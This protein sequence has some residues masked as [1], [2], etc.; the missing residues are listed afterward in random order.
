[1][2]L[3]GLVA[4]NAIVIPN[5]KIAA[6]LLKS[7]SID[8]ELE[9]LSGLDLVNYINQKQNLWTTKLSPKF[10][11]FTDSVKSRLM[12]VKMIEVPAEDMATARTNEHIS[13][14]AIPASFD[15]RTQWPACSA[16]IGSIRDQSACGEFLKDIRVS[17]NSGTV[18]SRLFDT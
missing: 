1:M 3:V 16:S 7:R 9:A 4:V 8:A 18:Y 10:A 6:D 17:S 13:D 2:A 11:H 12:G 15:A 5:Q 14:D